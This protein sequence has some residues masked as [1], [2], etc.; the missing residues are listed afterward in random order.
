MNARCPP[1]P[2]YDSP[3]SSGQG[4]KNIMKGLWAEIGTGRDHSSIT[5][6]DKTD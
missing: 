2:L 5:I 4:R 3:S 1:K 6:K